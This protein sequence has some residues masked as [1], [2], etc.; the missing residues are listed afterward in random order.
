MKKIMKY[1]GLSFL[2]CMFFAACEDFLT[3]IPLDAYSVEGKY[4]T[5]ADFTQA[6]AGVYSRNQ[7]LYADHAD[8][9]SR[10]IL[11]ADDSQNGGA[12]A[13]GFDQF[14]ENSVDVAF[15]N[16]G[17]KGLYKIISFSN[18]ILDR[19]DAAQFTDAALKDYIKGEAYMFR[20][21]AYWMLGWQFGGVPL[22]DKP[23]TTEEVLQIK[24][25]T[26]A[27]TFDFAIADYKRAI[28]LLPEAWTGSNIGRVTK[29]AAAGMLAR[30]YMFRGEFSQAKTYLTQVIQSGK[31]ALATDYRDC[32]SE[33][34]ENDAER[35]WS[36]Q[37]MSGQSGEGQSFS[38][39]ALPQEASTSNPYMPFAGYASAV[40]VSENM[41]AAYEPG[42][43][44][45]EITTVTGLTISGL[46]DTVSYWC[47][48]YTYEV[49]TPLTQS[50]WGI[51]IP[52]LRYTDIVMMYAEALNEEGYVAGGEAFQIV[53]EVRARAGLAP[54]D[55]AVVSDRDK[56]REA[57]KRERRVEF[58]WEGLRWLDLVRWGDAV[59][60]MNEH[61]LH[62]DEGGGR[63]YMEPHQ[64][65]FQIPFDQLSRYNNTDILWQ[66]PG[67]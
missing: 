53:N 26:Q 59:R 46:L 25:S 50:D 24:R 51:D 66:N 56:F 47:I 10:V 37:F 67:Y 45:K 34:H 1:I 5:Q 41:L 21:Y 31:Y 62:P 49:N 2:A 52:I 54:L 18:L 17:W 64:V 43:L 32:F 7:A 11:R 13:Y 58:C 8:W 33:D 65:L 29:Y 61:F 22:Y 36:V 60:V 12:Y 28:E 3:E 14:T 55:P 27:E 48:K 44:R 6:I 38:S 20:G 39:S 40:R 23:V 30:L 19:I 15:L 9:F 42:D 63:Y 57:I 4:K 35:V 16:N